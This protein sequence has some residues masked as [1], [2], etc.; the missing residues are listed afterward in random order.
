[1]VSAML[2]WLTLLPTGAWATSA[3]ESS[4][5][6]EQ[7]LGAKVHAFARLASQESFDSLRLRIAAEPTILAFITWDDRVGRVFPPKGQIHHSSDT[8][9]INDEQRLRSLLSGANPSAWERRDSSEQQLLYCHTGMLDACAVVDAKALALDL[10]ME[11][12]ELIGIIFRQ[13]GELSGGQPGGQ[14]WPLSL[15]AALIAL[16]GGCILY[17][18]HQRAPA[19]ATSSNI[20]S[21]STTASGAGEFTRPAQR[22]TA[23]QTQVPVEP[24]YMMADMR[25][26]P[27]Q[28]L[29]E[30]GGVTS[31]VSER[32][33]KL[34]GHF[35]LHP[36]EVISK[37]E[38]Y[39]VG[40]GRD[41]VASSRALEQHMINLRKKIDPNRNLPVIIET[42]HG[43]GYRFP[44]RA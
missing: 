15:L 2:I 13:P 36:N 32:D 31:Q 35:A 37:D 23:D 12:T 18:K 4:S 16:G 17:L 38:L 14:P 42:V 9:V 11:P 29:V 40:W 10:G 43:Q 26:K 19:T 21:S 5:L 6:L 30:R 8:V 39:N 28:Q 7:Q 22:A 34:L 20:A 27:R 41:F 3:P 1:M 24:E 25:V 33:L 44:S